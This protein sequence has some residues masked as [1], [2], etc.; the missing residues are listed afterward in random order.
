[1]KKII[2]LN[3]IAA[4]LLANCDNDDAVFN[5][6]LPKN[7]SSTLVYTQGVQLDVSS[8]TWKN[9]TLDNSNSLADVPSLNGVI[10][11]DEIL[12]GY[13]LLDGVY[14]VPEGKTLTID[15]GTHIEAI[16]DTSVYIVVKKGGKIHINGT[17]ENPVVIAT[18]NGNFGGLVICGNAITSNG[19]DATAEVGNLPYGGTDSTDNSGSIR[20]C[21]IKNAG[22]N[23]NADSQ[24]N[25]ISL[26]AVGSGTTINNISIADGNDDG[27]EFYGGSVSITNIYSANNTDDAIDWTEGWNGTV[28]NAYISHTLEGFSTALEGDGPNGRPKFQNLTVISTVE[29]I[30]LQFKKQS[31][32]DITNLYLEGYSFEIDMK[33][34]G[35]LSNVTIDGDEIV[36]ID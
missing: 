21:V 9:A 34:N 23:I 15:A 36:I 20:Y 14:T 22:A 7:D 27:V 33:D 10:T 31:G 25:G 18:K 13:Y 1:M 32:A 8:W 30:A 29:G 19:E 4:I 6:V 11:K 35:A 26:Y 24:Y 16:D 17:S 3:F 5:V 2:L 12:S 28:K